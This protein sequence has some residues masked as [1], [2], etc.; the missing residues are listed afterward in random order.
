[1]K[2]KGEIFWVSTGKP[3]SSNLSN[4]PCSFKEP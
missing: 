1:L 4:R 3:V 2:E